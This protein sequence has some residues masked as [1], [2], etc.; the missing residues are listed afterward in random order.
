MARKRRRRGQLFGK[1]R[2]EVI[3][4]PGAFSAKAKAAGMSTAAYAAQVRAPGSRADT[5][6]KRQ[7]ALAQT[8]AKW[9]RRRRRRGGGR[10]LPVVRRRRRP[11][12][13]A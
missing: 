11:R 10:Q 1:P 5:R 6:T 3:K 4:R 9:R 7:A 13:A 12:Q 8:F 2:G